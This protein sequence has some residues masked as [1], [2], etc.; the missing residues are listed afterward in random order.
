[1]Q[2]LLLVIWICLFVIFLVVGI[3]SNS[4]VFGAMSGVL[5][6]LLG[7]FIITTGIQISSGADIVEASDT[8]TTVTWTYTD[9]TLPY[10]TY[11]IVWGITLLLFSVYILYAN[12]LKPKG[13]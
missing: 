3:I 11:S 7:L 12:L 4:K 13:S 1:M 9:A 2:D 5:L 8:A 6:L 10:S